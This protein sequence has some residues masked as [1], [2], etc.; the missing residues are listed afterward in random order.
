M[1]KINKINKINLSIADIYDQLVDGEDYI[2]TLLIVTDTIIRT[3][4][5]SD[6]EDNMFLPNHIRLHILQNITH[7]ITYKTVINGKNLQLTFSSFKK[8]TKGPIISDKQLN[9]VFLIIYLLSLY[10]GKKCSQQLD[11][12]IFLTPFKKQ[13]PIKKN[14]TI[15]VEHVNTGFTHSGCNIKSEIVIFREEEWFKVLIHELFHNFHIDFSTRNISKVTRQ[16]RVF[17]RI[18]SDFAIYETYCETWARILNCFIKIFLQTENITLFKIDFNKSIELERV[19][20]LKQ[21]DLIMKQFSSQ[22]DYKE[23]S[24]VFCYYIL[25]AC[26]MNDYS[27]FIEWCHIN[28]PDFIKFRDTDKNVE[29]FA[30]LIMEKL[31]D[32]TFNQGI[33]TVKKFNIGNTKSLRMTD[34]DPP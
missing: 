30:M 2:S 12:N 31:E 34:G 22:S 23:D 24:N 16:L 19:F 6:V 29:A 3:R 5:I 17:C 27:G 8:S 26:L 1:S 13:L 4:C 10:S 18:D 11:I 14:A 25:T 28:N 21:A 20:S 9:S 33:A 32:P 15:G 7:S